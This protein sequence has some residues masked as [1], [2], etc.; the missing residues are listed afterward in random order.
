MILNKFESLCM[1]PPLVV[2]LTSIHPIQTFSSCTH[3]LLGP[4]PAD[5]GWQPQVVAGLTVNVRVWFVDF[6]EWY[7]HL[8]AIWNQQITKSLGS[9]SN[10]QIDPVCFINNSSSSITSTNVRIHSCTAAAIAVR[11][12]A[13]VKHPHP[14]SLTQ[15]PS[16]PP[17]LLL[18]HHIPT[19]SCPTWRAAGWRRGR[20][21]RRRRGAP[22]TSTCLPTNTRCSLSWDGQLTPDRRGSSVGRS[23]EVRIARSASIR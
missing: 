10:I 20:S 15:P 3:G 2:L 1:C 5:E 21:W 13:P 18:W 4:L 17:P 9:S 11:E 23:N 14:P 22:Q 12:E 16:R 19:A 7:R 6:F 8:L